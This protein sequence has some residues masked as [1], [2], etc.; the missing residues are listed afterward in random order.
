[1]TTCSQKIVLSFADN[2]Y[3]QKVEVLFQKTYGYVPASLAVHKIKICI[4]LKFLTERFQ[5]SVFTPRSPDQNAEPE[6]REV[7]GTDEN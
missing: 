2:I 4:H 5:F 3:P 1:M 6:F 7:F